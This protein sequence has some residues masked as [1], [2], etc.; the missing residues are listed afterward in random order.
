LDVGERTHDSE[1]LAA[2]DPHLLGHD[3]MVPSVRRDGKMA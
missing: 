3:E 1:H 2:V